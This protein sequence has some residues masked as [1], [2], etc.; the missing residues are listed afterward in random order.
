MYYDKKKYEQLIMNSPLF[1]IDR[2]TEYTAFKRESYRMVENL[3]CYLLSIN[4]KDYEPY[5]CEITETATRCINNFSPDK[6]VFLHY[7]NAAWKQEYSHIVGV[8]VQDDKYRGI[9]VTE[10]DRRA[11]RKYT[12]LVEQLGSNISSAELYERLSEAMELS[13]ERIIE[14]EKLGGTTVGGDTCISDEGDAQSIWDQIPADE[15]ISMRF[16]SEE[17]IESVLDRIE[18]AFCSLQARQKPIVSDLITIRICELLTGRMTER[19]S[20]ISE[21]VME[22]WIESGRLPTQR[23]IAEKFGRN[24]ASISRTI[25]DFIGKI[26]E[27]D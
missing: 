13:P 4:E 7:F 2:E 18:D 3:Y 22:M 12:R 11:V 20:F 17:E 1:S 14:L 10:A 26:R 16:E 8:K 27:T 9:K 21:S 15:D 5:G 25:K 6:G 19:F 24:E 23:E